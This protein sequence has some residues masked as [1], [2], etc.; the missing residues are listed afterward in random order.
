MSKVSAFV[1]RKDVRRKDFSGVFAGIAECLAELL[2]WCRCLAELLPW[3]VV[4]FALRRFFA[5]PRR[6]IFPVQPAPASGLERRPREEPWLMQ[7]HAGSA[8]CD[9]LV[10]V[11][12]NAFAGEAASEHCFW[13]MQPHACPSQSGSWTGGC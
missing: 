11:Q 8:I 1:W 4:V 2:P 9:D 10:I 7:P 3:C 13:L 6:L 5:P 12:R